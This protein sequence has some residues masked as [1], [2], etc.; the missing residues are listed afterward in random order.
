M[1]D[2][3][4][5]DAGRVGCIPNMLIC[6][7]R[8]FAHRTIRKMQQH[9][10]R[11]FGTHSCLEAMG[12]PTQRSNS[13]V[14]WRG[15]LRVA[16]IKRN[17]RVAGPVMQTQK[18]GPSRPLCSKLASELTRIARRIA[19]RRRIVGAR[20]LRIAVCVVGWIGAAGR[21]TPEAI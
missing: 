9:A 12:Y 15:A 16:G 1:A 14:S 17:S 19:V 5:F 6:G 7:N 8:E 3:R 13:L 21:T 18:G 11:V 4:Q 20:I 10:I 2:G